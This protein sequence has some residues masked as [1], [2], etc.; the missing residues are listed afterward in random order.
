MGGDWEDLE[1]QQGGWVGAWVVRQNPPNIAG[2][3]RLVLDYEVGCERG[4]GF[5]GGRAQGRGEA[6]VHGTGVNCFFLLM[7]RRI[8]AGVLAQQAQRAL[9]CSPSCPAVMGSL[10]PPSSTMCFNALALCL[11]PRCRNMESR[12]HDKC[13]GWVGFSVKMAHRIT[14][15]GWGRFALCLGAQH[16]LAGWLGTGRVLGRIEQ[17]LLCGCTLLGYASATLGQWGA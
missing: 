15:G 9:A 1:S 5:P 2:G 3:F 8:V 4:E 16:T 17:P 13:R 7:L 14:A 6:G 11:T 10:L 12:N